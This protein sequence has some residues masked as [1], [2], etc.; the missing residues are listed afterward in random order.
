MESVVFKAKDPVGFHARPASV[1]A[2]TTAKFAS[3][4][5]LACRGRE[6]NPTSILSIMALGINYNDEV[7]ITAEGPDE[8]EA[9]AAVQE[10]LQANNLL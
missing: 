1:L 2:S 3:K 7:V 10:V 4:F 9:I 5:K 8:R 6:V